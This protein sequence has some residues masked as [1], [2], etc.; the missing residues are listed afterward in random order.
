MAGVATRTSVATTRPWPSAVRAQ[1]LAD[2]ALER[3]GELDPDLLLLVRREDVDDAVDRLRGVLGVQGR[4]DEVTGLGGGQRDRDRLEVAHLA[5]QDDVGV[6]PQHVLEGVREGV[7]VL[8]H[9]ALVDQRSDWCV[10]RNSIGSSTV[11]MWSR[12]W[13][14]ARS[15]IEASVVDLPEPV[16]PVTSTKPRGSIAKFATD[17]G[18][19]RSSSFLI[20]NGMSR[21][22]APTRVALPVDV[23]AEPGLPGHRVGEVELEVLLELLPL[24]LGDRSRTCTRW[25]TGGVSTGKSSSGRQVPVEPE[26]RA[27]AGGQVQVG[28]AALEHGAEQDVQ[29]DVVGLARSSVVPR[30]YAP[31]DASDCAMPRH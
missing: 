14:L 20:S 5:D 19:P 31:S 15:T 8:A 9:L 28:G 10:C 12:R 26:L 6:L 21:N 2:D 4:E 1:R 22:A 29:V 18:M 30:A 3:A 25:M 7:R 23:D 13:R 17:G 27:G 11:M 24:L 16:G